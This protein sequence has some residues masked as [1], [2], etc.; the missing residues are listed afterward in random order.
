M[1]KESG[2]SISK[3]SFMNTIAVLVL[4]M[5]AAMILTQII[6][7]GSFDRVIVDGQSRVV[8]GT[9]HLLA[10]AS[11]LPLWHFFTAPFEV[12]AS[13]DALTAIV[14]I[15][16]IAIIGGS[17]LVLDRSGVLNYIVA[18]AVQ[19]YQ[20]SKYR[21]IRVIVFFSMAL[22]SVLGMFE[23]TLT[24]V[25]IAILVALSLGFDTLV[26]LGISVLAVGLGFAS[27]TFNPFTIGIAQDIAGLPLFSGVLLRI[28]FFAVVYFLYLFFLERYCRRIEARPDQSLTYQEDRRKKE[29]LQTLDVE[30]LIHNQALKKATLVFSA[31]MGL[32]VI[33][34]ILAFFIRSLSDYT[35]IVMAVFLM[36]GSLLAGRVSMN[37]QG[38][39]IQ[40]FL[41]GILDILP[42]ALLILLA[43]SV[44]QIMASGQIM[45]TIL[46]SLYLLIA[47]HH[48]FSALLIIFAFILIL[49]IFIPSSSAKAFLIMPLILSLVDLVGITRQT[50]VLAYAFG[51]G[52]ANMIYP[53]NALLLI[54]LGMANVK[55]S[56]WF[57]FVWKLEAILIAVCIG[58]LGLALV[59]NYGPF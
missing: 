26:G 52:F 43:L 29:S 2:L 20:T 17:F 39:L 46:N 4:I 6:P 27:G 50:A 15:G 13:E 22:G 16:V 54:A 23:E 14:I 18:V 58:F 47:S 34:V 7:Q 3:K 28:I 45:D 30:T 59:L 24:L 35:M 56:V 21:L 11:R 9:Y 12:F 36:I 1:K 49:E 8:E 57:K 10:N 32:V 41:K 5:V 38:S 25:P 37:T 53:T 55:Y 48:P 40:D 33:Y 31:A 44:K 19:R 42:A 51:D